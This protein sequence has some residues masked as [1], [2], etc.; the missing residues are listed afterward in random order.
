MFSPCPCIDIYFKS[1]TFAESLDAEVENKL[2]LILKANFQG[3][4]SQVII[5]SGGTKLL[6]VE[7][8]LLVYYVSQGCTDPFDLIGL[9]KDK[10]CI[11]HVY[12]AQAGQK[13]YSSYLFLRFPRLVPPQLACM[14]FIYTQI[15][16]QKCT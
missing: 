7:F 12:I 3:R 2:E 11:L 1:W 14:S 16:I 4:M 10:S 9:S 15:F 5:L 8:F 13:L 6:K